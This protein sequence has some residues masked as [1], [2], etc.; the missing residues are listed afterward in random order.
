V[1]GVVVEG[2]AL[3]DASGARLRLAGTLPSDDHRTPSLEPAERHPGGMRA[4]P[5][6]G[7]PRERFPE[8]PRRPPGECRSDDRPARAG[9]AGATPGGARA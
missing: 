6:N 3:V 8:P 4:L 7:D 1:G 2:E 9:A 5:G